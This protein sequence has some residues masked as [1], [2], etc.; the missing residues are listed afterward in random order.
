MASLHLAY[1][2]PIKQIITSTVDD[3][4]QRS[5]ELRIGQASGEADAVSFFH[6]RKQP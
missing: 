4:M 6:Q 5:G 1:H 2:A 3:E